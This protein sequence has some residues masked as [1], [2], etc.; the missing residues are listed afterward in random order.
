MVSMNA[1]LNKSEPRAAPE[2]SQRNR[3]DD[4]FWGRNGAKKPRLAAKQT[5]GGKTAQNMS[6]QRSGG[7]LASASGN[8]RRL[9]GLGE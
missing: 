2:V 6:R 8:S 3:R 9:Y 7:R 4:G 5:N 1:S